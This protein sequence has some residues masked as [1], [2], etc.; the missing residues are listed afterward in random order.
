[1]PP[2][3]RLLA[4]RRPEKGRREYLVKY[5]EAS[6]RHSLWK[7]EREV[8]LE[9]PERLRAFQKKQEK[10]SERSSSDEEEVVIDDDVRQ[11][12]PP[13]FPAEFMRHCKVERNVAS[14]K[15]RNGTK[16]YLVKW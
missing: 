6:F 13:D 8:Q 16:Q 10:D 11:K 14:K 5:K 9:C 15:I 7:R 3:E 4:M 12:L 1:M 2:V